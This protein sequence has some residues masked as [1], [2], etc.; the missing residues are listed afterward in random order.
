MFVKE[1]K[2]LKGDYIFN[3]IIYI[4]FKF[5]NTSLSYTYLFFTVV[6]LHQNEYI[7]KTNIPSLYNRYS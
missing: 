5:C 7:A 3:C 6:R 1:Q 4:E 2:I